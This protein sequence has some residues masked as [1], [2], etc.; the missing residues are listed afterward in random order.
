MRKG[1]PWI[2]TL[3]IMVFLAGIVAPVPECYVFK[4]VC[5]VKASFAAQT[6]S[7]QSG[8]CPARAQSCC[9][10]EAPQ[11]PSF[12]SSDVQAKCSLAGFKPRMKSYLPDIE[13]VDVPTVSQVLLPSLFH[14]P[15]S[16]GRIASPHC[17]EPA[18]Y[19]PDPIPILLRKQSLLI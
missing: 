19:T 9:V 17:I 2:S 1:T 18:S 16:Q 13:T 4:V 14:E 11:A 8:S 15:F 5:P 10:K 12:P 3:I 6:P 7:C